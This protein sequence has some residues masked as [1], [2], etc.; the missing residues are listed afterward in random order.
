MVDGCGAAR[1]AVEGEPAPTG[2]G[3]LRP[4]DSMGGYQQLVRGDVLRG[5]EEV[6]RVPD[7]GEA[8]LA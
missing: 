8:A 1:D 6:R 3:P 7:A 5:A 2:T 4:G